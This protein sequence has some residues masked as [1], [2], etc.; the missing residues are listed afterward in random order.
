MRLC[1]AI[2]LACGC[3]RI[4]F[5]GDAL[6]RVDA[7]SPDAERDAAAERA[8]APGNDARDDADSSS[9]RDAERD[10]TI[11]ASDAEAGDADVVTDA[12]PDAASTGEAVFDFMPQTFST[13]GG[14][15][16]RANGTIAFVIA[17][18]AIEVGEDMTF[19]DGATGT[20]TFTAANDPD[21]AML[22]A[23]LLDGTD[24]NV[25]VG[26]YVHG[27]MGGNWGIFSGERESVRFGGAPAWSRIDSI[28]LRLELVSL[29]MGVDYYDVRVVFVVRGS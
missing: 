22:A 7:G 21:F 3:G 15:D 25:N 14:S 18:G 13:I 16:E 20:V 10:A 11:D 23:K 1:L 24:D 2:L 26:T 6:G 4:G 8:D 19:T 29:P 28:D 12:A 17:I 9:T 5:D 27:D